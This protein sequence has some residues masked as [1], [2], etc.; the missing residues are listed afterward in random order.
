MAAVAPIEILRTPKRI[1]ILAEF[2]RS[3]RR[4]YLTK[5]ARRL[6]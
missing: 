3:T 1:A 6:E 2:Q 5:D 4:I